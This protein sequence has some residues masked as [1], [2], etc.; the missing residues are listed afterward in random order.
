[1]SNE[2]K[3]NGTEKELEDAMKALSD[4]AQNCYNEGVKDALIGAS[5]GA[6]IGFAVCVGVELAIPWIESK[7]EKRA[8]KKEIKEFKEFVEQES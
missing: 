5:I 7:R 1:M 6:V 4:F 3:N 8:L 2:I